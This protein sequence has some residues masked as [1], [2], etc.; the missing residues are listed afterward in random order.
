MTITSK[1]V[2][3]GNLRTTATH[4]AS[5]NSII[6]D[7]PIDNHGKGQAFSPTDLASTSVACCMMTIMGIAAET[8]GIDM[9]GAT[10]EITKVMSASPRKIAK[11][12][13]KLVMPAK[14]Y[15]KKEKTILLNASKGCPVSLSLSD[16][17][18]QLVEILW[19]D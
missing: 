13:I 8:H 6:T 11:V 2:Y 18:E 9:E 12:I 16:E 19:Q 15:S 10:A 17:V 7:A 14:A 4:I 3:N 5:G 1:V